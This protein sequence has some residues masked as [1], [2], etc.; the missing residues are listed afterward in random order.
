MW[1]DSYTWIKAKVWYKFNSLADYLLLSV[2]FSADV[3]AC[4]RL[5]DK[6]ECLDLW[7][8]ADQPRGCPTDVIQDVYLFEGSYTNGRLSCKYV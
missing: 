8:N 6:I 3:V 7:N 5:N 4:N 2:K 1:Y